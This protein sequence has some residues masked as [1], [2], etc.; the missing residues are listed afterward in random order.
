MVS[1]VRK[2]ASLVL[3]LIGLLWALLKPQAFLNLWLTPDQQGLL[4]FQLGDYRRASSRF[5]D[6]A[7]K[8]YS[9]YADEEFAA[10]ETWYTQM[11]T[12]E[13]LLGKAN[14]LA[15]QMRYPEAKA[16]YQ[17]LATRFPDHPASQTNIALMD[18]LIEATKDASAQ[19]GD[20]SGKPGKQ[21]GVAAAPGEAVQE[22][23]PK[24]QFQAEQL[25]QDPALTD[26]WLRQIQR[27]PSEFLSTKF[28]LQEERRGKE[29]P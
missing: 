23:T 16:A 2:R 20:R 19:G 27:D 8:G 10:A 14:A 24:E 15:H 4:W 26:M 13:A 12:A 1:T 25:L 21:E 18:R 28:Y 29:T 6:P 7:W 11:D 9:L 3:V 22:Q 17:A 5:E